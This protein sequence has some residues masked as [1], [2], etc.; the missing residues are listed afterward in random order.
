M[1]SIELHEAA[2]VAGRD[3][4]LAV[5]EAHHRVGLGGSETVASSD[6]L[7][8]VVAGDGEVASPSSLA[9]AEAAAGDGGGAKQR[10]RRE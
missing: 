9:G 8:A 1:P 2:A 7:G 6:Q 4:G 3:L 10:R 5:E